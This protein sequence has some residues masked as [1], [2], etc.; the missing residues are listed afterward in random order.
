MTTHRVDLSYNES[1]WIANYYRT[2]DFTETY[3][4]VC[5]F[6]TL[7]MTFQLRMLNWCRDGVAPYKKGV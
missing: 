7:T 5:P 3:L 2:D 4:Q 6:D 1:G